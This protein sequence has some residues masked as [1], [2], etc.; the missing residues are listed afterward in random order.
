MACPAAHAVAAEQGDYGSLPSLLAV[1]I[2]S[3]LVTRN[4]KRPTMI[5]PVRCH[6]CEDPACMMACLSGAITQGEDSLVVID[7][8]HCVGCRPC[9]V[10]CPYGAIVVDE[11][12]SV[13]VKCDPCDGRV[14]PA[15][16][17]ALLVKDA[18]F[19]TAWQ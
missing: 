18:S 11:S 6:Q 16:V 9:T 19:Q 8:D 15:C 3:G 14:S 13:A 5:Y 7:E 2:R 12:R 10:A 17:D 4:G 1:T